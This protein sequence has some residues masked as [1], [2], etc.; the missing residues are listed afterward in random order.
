MVSSRERRRNVTFPS[1]TSAKQADDGRA[2]LR[3]QNNK[4]CVAAATRETVSEGDRRLG[5]G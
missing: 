1:G 2:Q 4:Y 5:G 3:R